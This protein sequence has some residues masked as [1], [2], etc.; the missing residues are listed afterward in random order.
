M[1]SNKTVKVSL[2]LNQLKK[3]IFSISERI[4][5]II[6]ENDDD[7]PNSKHYYYLRLIPPLKC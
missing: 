7:I 6:Y 2:T 4:Q 5:E 1:S 3:L